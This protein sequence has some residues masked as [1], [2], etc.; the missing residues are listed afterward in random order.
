MYLGSVGNLRDGR[1]NWS[2]STL[3]PLE[4]VDLYVMYVGIGGNLRY[5]IT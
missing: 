3:C 4:L 2:E 1:G 5:V